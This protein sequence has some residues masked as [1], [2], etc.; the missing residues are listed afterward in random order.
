MDI[1]IAMQLSGTP[2]GSSKP[3]E[4]LADTCVT[5]LGPAER[6]RRLIGG[7]V[8]AALA[9][10]VLAALAYFGADRWWRLVAFP[11][12]WGAAI[13]FFQWWDRT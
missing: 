4:T 9:L 3:P 1:A 12:W 13:G 6:R 2:P 5:N 8:G 11:L 10:A 7:V